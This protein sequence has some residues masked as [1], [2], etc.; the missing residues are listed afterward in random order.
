MELQDIVAALRSFWLVWLMLIFLGIVAYAF[1]PRNKARF[2][3]A[4][5]IPFKDDGQEK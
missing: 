3:E 1:W 2:D 4:A 5:H